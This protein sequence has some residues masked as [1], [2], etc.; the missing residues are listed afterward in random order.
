MLPRSHRLTQKRDF[1]KLGTQ[2]RA[3]YGPYATLRVRELKAGE[4]KVAFITSTKMF[5]KA[6]DRNRIKRR[7]REIIRQI[8]N[9]LPPKTHLLFIAKPEARDADFQKIIDDI[10]HML[11]KIPEAMKKPPKMSP[12]AIKSAAKRAGKK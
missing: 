7:L 10:R 11:G 6:V 5:K 4:T 8:W 3:I 9:E 1:A 12:R 2:G